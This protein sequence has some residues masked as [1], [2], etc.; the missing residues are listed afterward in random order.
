MKTE[1]IQ[2]NEM[3]SRFSI[4]NEITENS[5]LLKIESAVKD[6]KGEFENIGNQV[7]EK[8]KKDDGLKII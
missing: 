7:D 3:A 8:L 1:K 2:M 5:C 6:L 4:A